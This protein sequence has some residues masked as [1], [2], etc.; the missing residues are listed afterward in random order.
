MLGVLVLETSFPRIRGDIGAADT[1]DFPVRLAR[2]QGASVDRVVHERNDALLAK[3]VDAANGLANDGCAGIVT[4]CGFLVRWQDALAAAIDVPVLTSP[5][6]LLPL[7]SRT[8]PRHRKV[9]VVTYSAA[10]L[11]GELSGDT[12]VEG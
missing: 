6:L 10:D 12:P 4:T 8:M 1:F 9:G 3:F 11:Q 5:L 2:V 7:V